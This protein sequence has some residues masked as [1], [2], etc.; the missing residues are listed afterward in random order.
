MNA[1]IKTQLYVLWNLFIINWRHVHIKNVVNNVD[2]SGLRAP[3]QNGDKMTKLKH[4]VKPICN[5]MKQ[6]VNIMKCST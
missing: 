5:K 3:W 4:H 1:S 6:C 2:M